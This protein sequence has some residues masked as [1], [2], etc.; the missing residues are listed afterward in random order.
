MN[1]NQNILLGNMAEGE[2]IATFKWNWINNSRF[3]EKSKGKSNK[4][5]VRSRTYNGLTDFLSAVSFYCYTLLHAVNIG[6]QGPCIS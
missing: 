2:N 1:L 6:M 5:S 3:K 4:Q